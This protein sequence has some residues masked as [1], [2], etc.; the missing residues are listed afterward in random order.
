MSGDAGRWIGYSASREKVIEE[1]WGVLA[2]IQNKAAVMTTPEA[3][4]GH[5]C[6]EIDNFLTERTRQNSI[7]CWDAFVDYL[8]RTHL[9]NELDHGFQPL[10]SIL[11]TSEVF[12]YQNAAG[13]LLLRYSISCGISLDD[14][15][16]VLLN[17]FNLSASNIVL[18]LRMT[19]GD[20]ALLMA[21]KRREEWQLTKEQQTRL[22]GIKYW[23]ETLPYVAPR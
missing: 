6:D 7:K 14:F 2:P 21:L 16:G 11:K 18:Y 17:N 4:A 9:Q 23:C 5:I 10:L 12:P 20:E 8:Y 13:Q 22:E 3:I 1:R 19:F 15:L